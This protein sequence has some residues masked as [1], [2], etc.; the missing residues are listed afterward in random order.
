MPTDTNVAVDLTLTLTDIAAALKLVYDPMFYDKYP[1]FMKFFGGQFPV[2]T[3]P[4]GEEGLVQRIRLNKG[5]NA[6]TIGVPTVASTIPRASS[7]R[8]YD[9]IIIKPH[10]VPT[11]TCPI[12]YF[13]R[14][15]DF[16]QGAGTP[17]EISNLALALELDSLENLGEVM[18][19]KLIGDRWGVLG[20]IISVGD[21]TDNTDLSQLEFDLNL[22]PK[23]IMSALT[24]GRRFHACPVPSTGAAITAVRNYD[25]SITVIGYFKFDT[26]VSGAYVKVKVAMPYGTTTYAA[27]AS[28]AGSAGAFKTQVVNAKATLVVTDVLTLYGGPTAST[29]SMP[30]SGPN[31][32]L[33]GLTYL[34]SQENIEEATGA[35]T[36]SYKDKE[37]NSV[38]RTAGRW[39]WLTGVTHDASAAALDLD[40]LDDVFMNLEARLGSRVDRIL[41]VNPQML[42]SMK[43][44]VGISAIRSTEAASQEIERRWAKFGFSG[45]V[46][47]GRSG[48]PIPV[49]E[50][51]GVPPNSVWMLTPDVLKLMTP[52]PMAWL[53]GAIGGVW[54]NRRDLSTGLRTMVY[55]ADRVI[56][57]TPQSLNI[58]AQ[59]AIIDTKP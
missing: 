5:D 35:I 10:H 2:D 57:A 19:L 55:E 16:G 14:D 58:H 24:K 50:H 33:P 9:Q 12:S 21:T 8:A 31:Y 51:I 18:D 56:H 20:D 34:F 15:D 52:K 45:V 37:G 27:S 47:Q 13:L 44:L 49:G 4:I 48:S 40:W 1:L 11:T 43:K 59:G 46:Y 17:D 23:T 38:D 30:T 26:T 25:C 3:Q 36:N 22:G 42:E 28:S 53:P 39:E 6:R 7:Q 32:G 41:Q 29:A 54:E